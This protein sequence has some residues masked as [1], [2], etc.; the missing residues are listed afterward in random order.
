LKPPVKFSPR[1]KTRLNKA[2]DTL[3]GLLFDLRGCEELAE[4]AVA[5]PKVDAGIVAEYIRDAVGAVEGA[6]S[7]V[8]SAEMERLRLVGAIR[9][10]LSLADNER[11]MTAER[12]KTIVARI[13]QDAPSREMADTLAVLIADLEKGKPGPGEAG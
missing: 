1:L 2:I 9:P 10:P 3:E 7:L 8:T 6:K 13:R 4:D 5:P 12:L 11:W